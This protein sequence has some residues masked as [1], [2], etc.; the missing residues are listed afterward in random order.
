MCRNYRAH[1][2]GHAKERKIKE[3][4]SKISLTID[5]STVHGRAYLIIYMRC[6]VSGKGDVDNVFLDITELTEG[7]DAESVYKSLKRSLLQA[8]LDD[9]FLGRNLIS[10][11]T[12]GAAVLTGKNT[13]LIARLKSDFPNIQS[14]HCLAHRL[15]LAVHD[16]L[17]AVAGCSHFEIFISKLYALYHQSAKNARLLEEAAA[18]LNM[19][20]LRIGQIFS[21]RWVASSFNTVKAVWNNYPALARHF[22]TASEDAGRNDAERKKYL[23]LHKHLTHTFVMDLAC[24]KDALRE[25]Q[26]LS[27]KLQRRDLSLVDATRHIQQTMDVLAAM[28]ESGGKSTLKAEQRASIGLFKDVELSEGREKINRRQFYQSVIDGLKMRMPESDLVQML[29]PLDK[30]FWPKD[31]NALILYG[32]HEVRKLAK[33][34]GE[35]VSEAVDG[36]RDWKLQDVVPTKTLGRLCTASRTYLPTSSE[37]ERGFSAVNNTDSKTRYRLREKSLSSLL[38]VDLIFFFRQ[39]FSSF[40]YWSSNIKCTVILVNT[41]FHLCSM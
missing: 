8:G 41:H 16:A 30:H 3:I 11:A 14:V 37:C 6:D 2:T 17:K 19:Q 10:I 23:G 27:L 1:R 31:R 28:K 5:E 22:Q 35:S 36:F 25:L 21:I 39:T 33:T 24:M 4:D 38:L 40:Y 15:E 34:L 18:D 9:V 29:K 12:D 32:E 7:T 13:G 26:G 20:V